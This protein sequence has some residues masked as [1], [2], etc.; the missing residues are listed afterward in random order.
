VP[1]SE[2]QTRFLREQAERWKPLLY[3][4]VHSGESAVYTPWDGQPALAAGQPVSGKKVWRG[5]PSGVREG[6]VGQMQGT[7]A[8]SAPPLLPLSLQ[9]DMEALMARIGG[10]CRCRAGPG[11]AASG[12]LAFGTGMDFMYAQAG[13]K[14]S[15]TM[16]VF[17]ANQ[18]GM[19]RPGGVSCVH[20]TLLLFPLQG[21]PTHTHSPPPL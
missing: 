15:L 10:L 1:F 5:F 7:P 9:K 21:K 2:P 16:E 3:V 18:E 8:M 17:G 11:G 4:N 14:Y 12:Y 20:L 19:L 6:W 13:V